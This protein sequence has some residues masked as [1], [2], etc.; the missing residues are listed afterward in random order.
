MS[1]IHDPSLGLG[2]DEG[3]VDGAPEGVDGGAQ[4]KDCPPRPERVA[5]LHGGYNLGTRSQFLPKIMQSRPSEERQASVAYLV[6]L[7]HLG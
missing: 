1:C 4:E 7:D 2:S 6:S 5:A 3:D